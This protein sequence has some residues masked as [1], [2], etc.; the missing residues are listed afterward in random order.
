MTSGL[1]KDFGDLMKAASGGA[2]SSSSCFFFTDAQSTVIPRVSRSG[3]CFSTHSGSTL[4]PLTSILANVKKV[5]ESIQLDSDKPRLFLSKDGTISDNPENDA[6][7]DELNQLNIDILTNSTDSEELKSLFS[8]IMTTLA[9]VKSPLPPLPYVS[10]KLLHEEIVKAQLL[11]HECLADEDME[12]FEEIA[13]LNSRIQNL[14]KELFQLQSE[15]LALENLGLPC[16]DSELCYTDGRPV[17]PISRLG[18]DP[19][20]LLKL[21]TEALRETKCAATAKA[22]ACA[23]GGGSSETSVKVSGPIL[24][25]VTGILD[26]TS[27][28]HPLEPKIIEEI[29]KTHLALGESFL[30]GHFFS[31]LSRQK[32]MEALLI[33][34]MEDIERHAALSPFE[35][36]RVIPCVRHPVVDKKIEGLFELIN[37]PMPTAPPKMQA[38]WHFITLQLGFDPSHYISIEDIKTQTPIFKIICHRLR[39][40][41]LPTIKQ[42]V[43]LS[44]IASRFSLT[45]KEKIF[46]RDYASLVLKLE[47]VIALTN[48]IDGMRRS[49]GEF[50]IIAEKIILD[51]SIK[52][53]SD[54]ASC[55]ADAYSKTRAT[56]SDPISF[57]KETHLDP[58]KEPLSY[59]DRHAQ[60]S[61]SFTQLL[62]DYNSVKGAVRLSCQN[63]EESR[64]RIHEFLKQVHPEHSP[65]FQALG[66]SPLIDED[67]VLRMRGLDT[68]SSDFSSAA[69]VAAPIFKKVG[70]F[71]SETKSISTFAG[72]ASS[73]CALDTA[74]ASSMLPQF[75][76]FSPEL[77][78]VPSH[79]LDYMMPQFS[80]SDEMPLL[81]AFELKGAALPL[82]ALSKKYSELVDA[83]YNDC[84]EA[85]SK[86][87]PGSKEWLKLIKYAFPKEIDKHITTSSAFIS[88]KATKKQ[89]IMPCAIKCPGGKLPVIYG[90]IVILQ[91][92]LGRTISREFVPIEA[93][94]PEH[95]VVQFLTVRNPKAG[96]VTGTKKMTV[97]NI[98]AYNLKKIEHAS[99]FARCVLEDKKH[100]YK[101]GFFK[102]K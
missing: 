58:F 28:E 88:E 95:E 24:E 86:T 41:L 60:G 33:D 49:L 35:D 43:L 94:P 63:G 98:F 34:L 67:I 42:Q 56:L 79:G 77:M 11:I 26:V 38:A 55:V 54:L 97:D 12:R 31:L 65:I 81:E 64:L 74:D 87:K 72:D 44:D 19:E 23:A 48:Q 73:E 25:L 52:I 80:L 102:F 76:A 27:H 53:E 59:Y 8:H 50:C 32:D 30:R 71:I 16:L 10:E 39:T 1:K 85:L 82:F 69:K 99:G 62:E 66:L 61:C 84:L 75:T 2:G 46:L 40:L 5:L 70:S 36:T 17:S 21:E 37:N 29:Q 89:S 100:K 6:S 90:A 4:L 96:P 93:F 13:P 20:T 14:S 15:K 18:T 3:S 47:H 57:S 91:G 78:A 22:S 7:I 9:K 45:Q 101:I 92:A 51:A 68:S 83:N